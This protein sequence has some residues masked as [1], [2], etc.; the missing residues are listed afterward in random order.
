MRSHPRASR[1]SVPQT[2]LAT[3]ARQLHFE[4]RSHHQAPNSDNAAARTTRRST[5]LLYMSCHK[6]ATL[7]WHRRAH[8]RAARALWRTTPRGPS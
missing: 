1:K 6:N 2:K 4:L 3:S 7:Q 8:A 5:R